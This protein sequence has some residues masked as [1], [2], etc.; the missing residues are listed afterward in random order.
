MTEGHESSRP[1]SSQPGST[2]CARYKGFLGECKAAKA[3]SGRLR[4]LAAIAVL[5]PVGQFD[6][7]IGS[8]ADLADGFRPELTPAG[9]VQG[10]DE[11]FQALGHQ[12]MTECGIGARP[13]QV[14]MRRCVPGTR[15]PDGVAP[16]A[17]E[18]DFFEE[19]PPRA[20]AW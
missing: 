11:S 4:T 12:T 1:F 6:G 7:Q 10:G 19:G 20:H 9:P 3:R 16:D 2:E 14:V 5:Q 18:I 8:L 17:V 15:C 13:R